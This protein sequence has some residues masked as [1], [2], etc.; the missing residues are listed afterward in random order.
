MDDKQISISYR[1]DLRSDGQAQTRLCN[2]RIEEISFTGNPAVQIPSLHI[3]WHVSH[4]VWSCSC[5]CV[6]YELNLLSSL[7]D[8]WFTIPKDYVC[9][10][11]RALLGSGRVLLWACG[12]AATLCGKPMLCD[13]HAKESF[14]KK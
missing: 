6:G 11:H 9:R 3:P 5:G 7:A 1:F 12:C 13:K 14:C 8:K 2:K 4:T 10:T